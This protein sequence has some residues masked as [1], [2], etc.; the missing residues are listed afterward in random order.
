VREEAKKML[1]SS[2][3]ASAYG[4]QPVLLSNKLNLNSLIEEERR[5]AVDEVK[6]CIEE[7]AY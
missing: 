5:E 4:V 3:V 7:A 6:K 1:E 2:H